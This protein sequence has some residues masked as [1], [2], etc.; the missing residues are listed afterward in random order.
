MGQGGGVRPPGRS[1]VLAE[2]LD[3]VDEA[4]LMSLIPTRILDLLNK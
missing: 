4:G 2:H 3:D 1:D